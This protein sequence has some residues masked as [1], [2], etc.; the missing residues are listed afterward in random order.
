MEIA[1]LIQGYIIGQDLAMYHPVNDTPASVKSSGLNEDLGQINFIFSDKTGTLTCN[2]MDFMKFSVD[3]IA[4]GTGV[5]E[6]ARSAAK[7]E[8]R[9]IIDDRPAHLVYNVSCIMSIL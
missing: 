3:G 6:I 5:T 2:K 8:G 1:K 4:Y 9:Q 7:R